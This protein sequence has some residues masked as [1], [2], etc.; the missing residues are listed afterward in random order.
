VKEFGLDSEPALDLYFPS[1]RPSY[2]VVKTAED[3]LPLAAAVGR[4]IREFDPDL[5]ISDVQTMD[6]VLAK[7]ARS[8]RWTM[9]L[10]GVFAALA[11]ILALVGIYGVMSWSVSQRTREIGIRMALGARA[12]H[13]RGM[14][15]RS[16]LE[17]SAIGLVLGTAGALALRRVLAS[18]VFGVS[19]ADPL[20]YGSVALL[21]LSV[22][23]LA[24]YLPA[25]RASRVDP[26]IA[27]RQE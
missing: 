26:L 16:G 22:A 2:L 25:R 14:V 27:L 19:T 24:C 13:V 20:I 11:L 15:I 23:I 21:M 3:P 18:F 5:A 6:Q 10:L 1:L 17:L 9:A 12:G 4:I 8:R 7:S